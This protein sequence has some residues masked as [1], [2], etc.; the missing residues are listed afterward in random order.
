MDGTICPRAV[1]YT[2]AC[3]GLWWVLFWLLPLVGR[4][5][6]ASCHP[7]SLHEFTLR[8]L[9][10]PVWGDRNEEMLFKSCYC[11][12]LPLNSFLGFAL[13][14]QT[15][16][17]LSL[18]HFGGEQIIKMS[19]IYACACVTKNNA[20]CSQKL[21]SLSIPGQ[22]IVLSTGEAF[23]IHWPQWIKRKQYW[24][25]GQIPLLVW[26]GIVSLY[27]LSVASLLV[28]VFNNYIIHVL[29][30]FVWFFFF[31]V[32][33]VVKNILFLCVQLYEFGRCLQL[34]NYW[35]K[36]NRVLSPRK[37]LLC[38]FVV[39]T[40]LQPLVPNNPCFVQGFHLSNFHSVW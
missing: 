22:S 13:K 4:R 15:W 40:S 27:S 29:F 39:L 37:I 23:N 34:C 9:T 7:S 18:P 38:F 36:Q 20:S 33:S 24:F 26:T 5:L 11:L 3:P 25:P 30:L 35:C 28:L 17:E 12:V 31:V 16:L 10:S 2:A 1:W 14:Q 19:I 8:I 32:T 6:F 21:S